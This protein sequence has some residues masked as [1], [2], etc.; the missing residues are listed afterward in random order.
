MIQRTRIIELDDRPSVAPTDTGDPEH[1]DWKKFTSIHSDRSHGYERRWRTGDLLHIERRVDRTIPTQY[2]IERQHEF[3]QRVVPAHVNFEDIVAAT[4][5]EL[6][7]DLYDRPWD[8]CDGYEHTEADDTVYSQAVRGRNVPR[9]RY[10]AD[11]GHG[12]LI[13]ADIEQANDYQYYRKCGASKQVA[14]EQIACRVQQTL[15]QLRQWYADGWWWY[16]VICD[17][18]GYEDSCGGFS[19]EDSAKQA[20][21]EEMPNNVAY[22]MR[23]DGYTVR[24]WPRNNVRVGKTGY[25]RNTYRDRLRCQLNTQNWFCE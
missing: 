17:F 9:G 21:R 16:C 11:R 13:L 25:T 23:G 1:P 5:V 24:N 15:D 18:A 7:D 22:Q 19:D 14:R 4:R 3:S 2:G 20:S 6:D 8:M 10:I 12:L